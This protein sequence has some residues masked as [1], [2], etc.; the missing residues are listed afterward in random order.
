MWTRTVFQFE[1][2]DYLS[3]KDFLQRTEYSCKNE[4]I[5]CVKKKNV[6]VVNSGM[7]QRNGMITKAYEESYSCQYL[8]TI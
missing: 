8:N 3:W 1:Q 4:L 2:S 5:I 7:P 6:A